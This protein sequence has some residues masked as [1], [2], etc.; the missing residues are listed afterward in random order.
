MRRICYRYQRTIA[1]SAEVQG[2]GFLTGAMVTLR[3]HPAPPN[4]GVVFAR[5][6]LGANARIPA[7]VDQVTGTQRRTTLGKPPLQVGL[8]EHVLAALYGLRIDNCLVELNALDP[9]GMDGSARHFCEALL[10]AGITLQAARR[11]V[12]T[13]S[14]PLTIKH[15]GAAISLYPPAVDEFKLSYTL[16]YGN[17]SPIG[18]QSHTQIVTPELFATELADHR[19]FILES[20]EQELRRQGLGKHT[21][22]ADLLVFGPRGPIDNR[23]RRANEP[24]RHKVLDMLGDISLF[25]HDLRGHVVA[26]RSGHSLNVELVRALAREMNMKPQRLAA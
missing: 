22:T 4:S 14:Q 24:A 7:R 3:F 15:N 19:T 16:D 18:R 13:V 21:T 25:G 23:V 11:E 2:V 20:E 9:P 5:A 17:D 12:W 6:D 8:V 10:N 1:R 26:Y